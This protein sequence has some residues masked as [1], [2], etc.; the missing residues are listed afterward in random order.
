MKTTS[1]GFLSGKKL[2]SRINETAYI[3]FCVGDFMSKIHGNGFAPF[4]FFTP[5]LHRPSRYISEGQWGEN[6]LKAERARFLTEEVR[7]VEP[8]T[9]PLLTRWGKSGVFSESTGLSFLKQTRGRFHRLPS[10]D[11]SGRLNLQ[12]RFSHFCV[13]A[14]TI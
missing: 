8:V 6:R 11:D 4:R 5:L 12:G 2:K 7:R 14:N 1:R 10:I 13:F 9:E 3:P